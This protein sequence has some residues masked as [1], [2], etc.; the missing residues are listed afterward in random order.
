M[1]RLTGGILGGLFM[2]VPAALILLASE[3]RTCSNKWLLTC[4]P[5]SDA[6]FTAQLVGAALLVA[7]PY[8]GYRI[9]ARLAPHL[10]RSSVVGVVAGAIPGLASLAWDWWVPYA[11]L[12]MTVGSILGGFIA[13]LAARHQARTQSGTSSEAPSR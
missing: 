11:A 6:V 9:G 8:V 7:G 2:L 3:G 13:W 12:L 4:T 1:S 10:G 5:G